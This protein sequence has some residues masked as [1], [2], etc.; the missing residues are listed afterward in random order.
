MGERSRRPGLTCHLRSFRLCNP[1]SLCFCGG[2]LR[3]QR[4]PFGHASNFAADPVHVAANTGSDFRL[5]QSVLPSTCTSLP[6]QHHYAQAGAAAA[7]AL[8]SAVNGRTSGCG[9]AAS[10]SQLWS[11]QNCRSAQC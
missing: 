11:S 2:A 1:S 7:A 9:E 4:S 6:P 8:C 3:V 5:P 10:K